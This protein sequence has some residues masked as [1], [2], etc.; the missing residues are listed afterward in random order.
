MCQVFLSLRSTRIGSYCRASASLAGFRIGR[1]CACPT[2]AALRR[3]R[4]SPFRF[5]GTDR[6]PHP[7]AEPFLTLVSIRVFR[8]QTLSCRFEV[9]D[10]VKHPPP[11][12]R[13]YGAEIHL[14]LAAVGSLW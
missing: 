6:K 7:A 12:G 1:R 4:S 5:R 14:L 3:R 11:N 13:E 9:E 10:F 8:G 2:R